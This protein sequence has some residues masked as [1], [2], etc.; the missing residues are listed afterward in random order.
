[1]RRRTSRA[2]ARTVVAAG[3]VACLAALTACQAV[4][5]A[6]D[7]AQPLAIGPAAQYASWRYACAAPPAATRLLVRRLGGR[8]AG[9]GAQAPATAWITSVTT[10]RRV[11]RAL[12]QLP[13]RP[14]GT[15]HC[16][17]DFGVSYSL[18]FWAGSL[19]LPIVT[20]APTGCQ[21]VGGMPGP[22]RWTALSP[23]FWRVLGSA[24]GLRQASIGSFSSQA[25]GG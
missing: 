4:A 12:C 15:Y 18:S 6:S 14:P 9:T 24:L 16:P 7:R 11:E 13:V 19:A 25:A 21:L 10:V 5:P 8:V 23:G 20:V 3:A 2:R 22:A 1:V 17:A